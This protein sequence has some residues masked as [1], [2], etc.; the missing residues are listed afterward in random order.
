MWWESSEK[1]KGSDTSQRSQRRLGESF[2]L[3]CF[4]PQAVHSSLCNRDTPSSDR[5]PLLTQD[6]LRTDKCRNS[7]QWLAPIYL[8]TRTNSQLLWDFWSPTEIIQFKHCMIE[9][10]ILKNVLRGFIHCCGL[11]FEIQGNCHKYHKMKDHW[12]NSNKESNNTKIGE[13]SHLQS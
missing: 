1:K 2:A 4:Q 10:I 7:I 3:L 9:F 12:K 13:I 6:A 5:M 11:G 8:L